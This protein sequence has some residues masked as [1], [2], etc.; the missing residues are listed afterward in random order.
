MIASVDRPA[1]PPACGRAR[2]AS[3]IVLEGRFKRP[4][5]VPKAHFLPL[6]EP[7]ST[8]RKFDPAR[9]QAFRFLGYEFDAADLRVALRYG[10][11]D[12]VV[13]EEHI[14]FPGGRPPRDTAARIALERALW[15]LHLT[16]GVSYYK[17]A[18]P[19]V[20]SVET[21]PLSD[22][23]ESF[24]EGLYGLGLAEF[25]W[26]NDLSLNRTLTFRAEKGDVQASGGLE[27]PRRAAVPVGG[28]KDSIVTIEALRGISEPMVLFSVGD[29]PAIRAT[30]RQ[31]GL[32]HICVERRLSPNL[33]E[34]NRN[35]AYNGHVP[36]TA[37]VSSIA[38][39]AAIL[40]GFDVIAMS[41]ERS[42]S[43]GNLVVDGIDVNHQY[44]KG[45]DFELAFRD[46]LRES[47]TGDALE[48]FSLLRPASELAI[49]RAFAR[50]TDYHQSFTS[51]NTLFR[52]DPSTRGASWCGECPK[53]RFVF[54]I[55]APF[56]SVDAL[57]AIFGTNLLDRPSQLQ[58]FQELLGVGHPKPFECVGQVE[59]S[60]AAFR[61]L[62]EREEWRDLAIVRRVAHD[63]L[64]RISK[65]RSAPAAFFR[66][67]AQHNLT[68]PYED[69][70]RAL[71][72]SR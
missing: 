13:F 48:Y 39:V 67:D 57:T 38:C 23:A 63:H 7:P 16:A 55:L 58:G 45:L 17:T 64:P 29:F 33:F 24:L 72:S 20:L 44:S 30:V 18:A 46:L 5:L 54:L 10:L 70:V 9:Y 41:N 26:T 27:L 56:M 6:A 36:V 2:G 61:L 71:L 22:A 68:P 37:V 25:A 8:V 15:L 69:A 1:S 4:N 32:E 11:D 34:L 53:C 59:E 3:G 42:A 14:R 12:E 66:L 49:G 19:A 47:V 21:H 65:A 28:G 40:Y 51:C 43:Y 52:I 50:L 60:A 31:A 35:G 62:S